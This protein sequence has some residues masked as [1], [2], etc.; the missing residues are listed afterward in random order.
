MNILFAVLLLG[1]LAL[2]AGI[3]LAIASRVFHIEGDPMMERIDAVLPQTQCGQCGY[4]GCKPYATAV[5]SGEVDVN[6]CV[7]GG[8]RAMLAIAD[9]MGVPPKEVEE[10]AAP[11]MLAYIREDECI[12]CTLCIKAC[13]VDAII[14]APKQYHT[15]VES[16]CTGCTLCVEPCPVDCID[17]LG[18]PEVLEE[19]T[20]SAPGKSRLVIEDSAEGETHVRAA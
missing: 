10:E 8:E 19:W 14:G 15:V 6:K 9:L 16:H 1:G 12:G 7:P 17:M 13:P 5:A 4:P 20:W 18:K 2:L 3:V 11:P